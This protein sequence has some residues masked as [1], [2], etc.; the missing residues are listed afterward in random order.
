MK[1]W[2]LQFTNPELKAVG[3]RCDDN[4]TTPWQQKLALTS[5]T[6]GGHSVVTVLLATKGHAVCLFVCLFVC[7]GKLRIGFPCK[8]VL[9][10]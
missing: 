6:S 5:P 10:P 2:R 3:I 4:A 1:N 9:K 8:V 7:I